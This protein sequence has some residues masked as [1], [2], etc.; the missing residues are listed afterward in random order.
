MRG[1]I[2]PDGELLP[3]ILDHFVDANKMS[4]TVRHKREEKEA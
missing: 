4:P 2:V 3:I 1:A